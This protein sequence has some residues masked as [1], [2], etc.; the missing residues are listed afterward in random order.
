MGLLKIL[1][2]T[3]LIL[4]VLRILVTVLFPYLMAMFVGKMQREAQKQYERQTGSYAQENAP[5]PDG[6]VRI[7]YV[8]PKTTKNKPST[9][10]GG[11]GEFVEF[12][13]IK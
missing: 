2:V 6:K 4:W 7:D 5:K 9:T 10:N 3:I 1:L 11:V 13:E 12:E 8:P